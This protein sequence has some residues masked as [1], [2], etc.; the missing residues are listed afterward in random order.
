MEIFQEVD[1]TGQVSLGKYC[2]FL[3]ETGVSIFHFFYFFIVWEL[4]NFIHIKRIWERIFMLP[5]TQF[6]NFFFKLLKPKI[7]WSHGDS[8]AK[9]IFHNLSLSLISFSSGFW[10]RK[11]LKKIMIDKNWR[12][13]ISFF[14]AVLGLRYCPRAFSSCCKWGPPLVAVCRLLIAVTCGHG[15]LGAQAS[16]VVGYGLGCTVTCGIVPNQ[17]SNLCPTPTLCCFVLLR[18]V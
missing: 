18:G 2:Y 5:V 4:N 10:A 3:N 1:G 6:F 16:A 13:S 8:A 14:L 17:E 11:E 7:T 9:I 15:L 12:Q